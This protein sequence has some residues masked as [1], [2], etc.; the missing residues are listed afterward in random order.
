MHMSVNYEG[1][2]ICVT[3]EE[4]GGLISILSLSDHGK[5]NLVRFFISYIFYFFYIYLLTIIGSCT[6]FL[7]N[8]YVLNLTKRYYNN[9][10]LKS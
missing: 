7:D 8:I 10:F 9:I 4:N 2:K 5:L 1:N 6:K 3:S